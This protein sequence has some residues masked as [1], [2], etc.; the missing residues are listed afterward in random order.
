MRAALSLLHD[1][2]RGDH[3][4]G[5]VERFLAAAQ[6][7]LDRI[8]GELALQDA[9]ERVGADDIFAIDRDDD[10]ACF[11]ADAVGGG[12]GFDIADD[13]IAAGLRDENAEV[14]RRSRPGERA[15]LDG[16][17][18]SG[19]DR[20]ELGQVALDLGLRVER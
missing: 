4:G 2:A 16:R 5:E 1:A 18:N 15:F 14:A 10:V 19:F 6:G 8:A 12:T 11:D 7:E 17:G 13:E 9:A 20:L 3:L